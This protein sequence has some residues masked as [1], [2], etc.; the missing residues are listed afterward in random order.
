MQTP[1][2]PRLRRA[3]AFALCALSVALLAGCTS[4]PQ[5]K[6][7]IDKRPRSKEYFAESEYGVKASPRVA[8]MR[9]GGGRDQL[10]KPYQ[11][12]GK[13]YYPKEDKRYAKVGLASWY[14]DAFHGRLTA[15]GEVYDTA[16]LT[17]A[18]PTMPLPSYARVTNLE[19]GSSVIVRVNDRG[20]YHEGR[21]IDVSER[22]AQML[23]YDRVGTAKVKVEYVGR[24]P[25]D[26]ND[27]QYLMASYRP[28]N[29]RPDPSDG[30]PTGV[31][32]AMNGPSPSLS[33]SDAPP[34][35]VPFPGQLTSSGQAF[36]SQPGLSAQPTSSEQP[37]MSGQGV[38]E[39]VLPDFGPIVPERPEFRLPP[40]SPF[41]MASLSYA[42]ERVKRADVFA[43]LDAS[44]MSPADILQSW[45]K[46][47]RQDQA[48]DSDYVAAGS[49]DDAVQAK[50]VAAAL[51]R[52]GRTEIQRTELDGNDWYAVNVYPNGHGSI[53]DLLKA[54][55]SHGAPD[56]LVVRN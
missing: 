2:R 12:R 24:A 36:A 22:V 32:V 48:P 7:M 54:A 51:E 44:G 26:G 50:R 10:G 11:V 52:F 19:T 38:S 18:H 34:P 29:R 45:K 53:D 28:G 17:A 30:L 1:A 5:P 4:T 27:D 6:A 33:M 40:N 9:R 3:P 13:W 35:A 46:S 43:A 41:A 31:M 37:A 25:L 42:D 56:A 49:F 21:I 47:N 23:D 16:Q 14:G 20:P 15:N 55:W 39:V 8:F